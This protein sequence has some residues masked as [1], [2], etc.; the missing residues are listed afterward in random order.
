[1]ARISCTRKKEK[2]KRAT[3]TENLKILKTTKKGKK[4]K[5]MPKIQLKFSL[6]FAT[7]RTTT[8]NKQQENITSASACCEQ[9]SSRTSCTTL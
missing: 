5:N 8:Q 1:M 7:R 2:E 3:K 4:V 9:R 6:V